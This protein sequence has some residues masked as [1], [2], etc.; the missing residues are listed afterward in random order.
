MTAF[1][2]RTGGENCYG[3]ISSDFAGCI[4]EGNVP[5]PLWAN[6]HFLNA[7]EVPSMKGEAGLVFS[8]HENIGNIDGVLKLFVEIFFDDACPEP[9]ATEF[10]NALSE[11]AQQTLDECFHYYAP[12]YSP[13]NQ[14]SDHSLNAPTIILLIIA[15]L[16][17]ASC[18]APFVIKCICLFTDTSGR[19]YDP[20]S[21]PAKK[22]EDIK[23]PSIK[24]CIKQ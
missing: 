4:E 20:E 18:L 22:E 15:G 8:R 14:S 24:A 16:T 3:K 9:K 23:S 5:P 17:V 21:P 1:L 11:N 2:L 6:K 10:V 12:N 19:Y 7:T 13:N